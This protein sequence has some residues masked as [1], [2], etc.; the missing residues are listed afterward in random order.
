[1][2]FVSSEFLAA[3]IIENGDKIM[4]GDNALIVTHNNKIIEVFK[5]VLNI[6]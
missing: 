6:Q 1:M 3:V 4:I 5:D 2:I